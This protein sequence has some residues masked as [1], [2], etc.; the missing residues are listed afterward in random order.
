MN[1]SFSLE[2]RNLQLSHFK[3]RVFQHH[4]SFARSGEAALKLPPT[5]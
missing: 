4:L 3:Q 1:L 2:M 5:P